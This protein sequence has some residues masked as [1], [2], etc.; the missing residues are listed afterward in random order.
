MGVT[1]KNRI[2]L[3]VW[4]KIDLVNFTSSEKKIF[5]KKKDITFLSAKTGEG[6][7]NLKKSISEIF[8]ATKFKEKIFIPFIKTQSRSWLFDKKLVL[9]E[10]VTEQGFSILV[11]WNSDQKNKF[12]SNFRL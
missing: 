6:I 1:K 8:N 3:E 9:E 2:I 4:N 7:Q 5:N 11:F 12:Y 10:K